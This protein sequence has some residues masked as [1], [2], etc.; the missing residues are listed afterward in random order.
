MEPTTENTKT[1]ASSNKILIAIAVLILLIVLVTAGVLLSRTG[2]QQD[3]SRIGYA[4][5]ATVMLDE[6][7][8][9][10]AMEEAMANAEDG[11]VG[12]SYAN[13]AYSKDGINFECYIAN[14]E[15]NLYDMFLT[16]FADENLKDE[17]FLSGL[18]PPGSGFE[19]ITLERALE[20]GSHRVYVGIT[21]VADDE[22]GE[23]VIKNQVFHTMDFHVTPEE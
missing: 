23:Q 19:N 6:D 10:K 21:Q 1:S 17:I 2:K 3:D 15:S 22:N 9:A 11:Y 4:S 13:D 16:I 8:L 7:S 18:V 20:E 5:D 12:L 14:S